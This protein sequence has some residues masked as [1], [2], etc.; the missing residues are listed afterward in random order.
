MSVNDI[1]PGQ[2]KGA[3]SGRPFVHVDRISTRPSARKSV[4]RSVGFVIVPL[5]VVT[6][7]SIDQVGNNHDTRE[8]NQEYFLGRKLVQHTQDLQSCIARDRSPMD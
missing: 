6:V 2:Q 3:R 1:A 7:S 8:N 4:E 5:E